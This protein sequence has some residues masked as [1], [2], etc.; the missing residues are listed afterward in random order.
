L[1]RERFGDEIKED[2][3]DADD[4]PNQLKCPEIKLSKNY[5]LNFLLVFK[6]VFTFDIFIDGHFN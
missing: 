1:V 6:I 3:S 4:Q 2:N 5:V